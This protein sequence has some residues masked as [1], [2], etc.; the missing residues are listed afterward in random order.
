MEGGKNFPT[1][2]WGGDF[3]PRIRKG[4]GALFFLSI[5]PTPP[6]PHPPEI[7]NE[8]SLTLGVHVIEEM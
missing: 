2:S 7:N 5:L 1:V 4:G 8:R 3:F 6:S